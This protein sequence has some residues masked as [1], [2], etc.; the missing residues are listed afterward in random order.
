LVVT[1][2]GGSGDGISVYE[3][4]DSGAQIVLDVGYRAAA[5]TMP[6]D[7]LGGDIGFLIVDSESTGK[8]LQATRYQYRDEKRQFVPTGKVNFS[9]FIESV[10][11]QF[12]RE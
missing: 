2:K 7:E 1:T 11:A 6:N 3:V 10:K 5:I 12:K 8:P 9:Q 4:T